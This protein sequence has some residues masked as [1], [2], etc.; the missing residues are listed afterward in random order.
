MST[1]Q[2]F[3]ALLAGLPEKTV[4]EMIH[5]INRGTSDIEAVLFST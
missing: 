5:H 1:T 3:D 4:V 2:T